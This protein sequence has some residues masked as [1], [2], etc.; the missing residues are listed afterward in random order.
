MGSPVIDTTGKHPPTPWQFP[1]P[2]CG[3]KKNYVATAESGLDP[4]AITIVACQWPAGHFGP[5]G[6]TALGS[7]IWE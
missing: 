5:H 4:N 3:A 2:P 1:S 6:I 7:Y